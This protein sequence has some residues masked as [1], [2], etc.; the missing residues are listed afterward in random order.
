MLTYFPG[1]LIAATWVASVEAQQP[2]QCYYPGRAWANDS[3]PCDPY[4]ITTQCCPIGWTCFSNF[5]CV[6]TDL[7]IVGSSF[8]L[9]TTIR[10]SCTNP[11]WNDGFCGGFCLDDPATPSS[12]NNGSM[13]DC[14]GGNWCCASQAADGSCDC[15]TGN[16][17]FTI[18]QG[19]AQT[20]ISVSSLQSTNTAVATSTTGSVKTTS[21]D[22]STLTTK[23]SSASKTTSS[24]GTS[25]TAATETAPTTSPTANSTAHHTPVTDTVRFKASISVGAV[26]V[27]AVLGFLVYCLCCRGRSYASRS[28]KFSGRPA[29][30]ANPRPSSPAYTAVTE[31]YDF[32]APPSTYTPYNESSAY[33]NP[34][35]P[36]DPA[37]Y[38]PSSPS[39]LRNPNLEDRPVTPEYSCLNHAPSMATLPYEGT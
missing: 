21:T 36:R 4:A 19:V 8:P 17:T 13:V 15:S 11:L 20:I 22:S 32:G 37:P 10:G 38:S 28:G 5:A 9:G 2:G 12:A 18:P 35:P 7:T 39:P 34:I 25:K 3:R 23:T 6:V 14:G 29:R 16:G 1:L 33:N 24:T 27:A 26:A 30:D 31:P